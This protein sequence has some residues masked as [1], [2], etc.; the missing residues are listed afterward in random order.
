MDTKTKIPTRG[1]AYVNFKRDT[2]EEI[3]EKAK[4]AVSFLQD[5][6]VYLSLSLKLPDGGY[7]PLTGWFNGFKSK[8]TDPDIIIK[9][10]V[11]VHDK[12]TQKFKPKSSGNFKPKTAP[13]TAPKKEEDCPW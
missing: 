11:Q 3:R 8:P 9:E 7:E 1:S 12:S 13:Q 4:R 2:S 5:N 6:G 10:K